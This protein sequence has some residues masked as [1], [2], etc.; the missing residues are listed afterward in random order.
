MKIKTNISQVQSSLKNTLQEET[1]RIKTE[2]AKKLLKEITK[3]AR[4]ELKKTAKTFIGG[5][6]IE[7]EEIVLSGK[8]NIM[9]EE[10]FSAYDMRKTLLASNYKIS[11]D[12]S[13]YKVIKFDFKLTPNKYVQGTFIPKKLVANL[14]NTMV[15][16]KGE[17]KRYGTSTSNLPGKYS[18]KSKPH[19]KRPIMEGVYKLKKFRS[20]IT[21]FSSFRTI[22]ENSSPESWQH[23]GFEGIHSFK[24]AIENLTL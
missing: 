13:K 6:S 9:L 2:T 8:F 20:G 11:K 23:P 24:K 22:S 10:G 7:G 5:L 3:V 1:K 19:H 16:K 21:S 14:T 15:T 18:E 12:G 4:A 17:I